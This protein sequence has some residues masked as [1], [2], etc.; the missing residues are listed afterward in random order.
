MVILSG[1]SFACFVA[2]FS[3]GAP[4]VVSVST[5]V[6]SAVSC[7]VDG[8]RDPGLGASRDPMHSAHPL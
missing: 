8:V 3:C 5:G 4:P 6:G 2:P 1:Q 7:G